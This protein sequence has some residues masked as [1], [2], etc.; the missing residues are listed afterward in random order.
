MQK[1]QRSIVCAGIATGVD[2]TV[3]NG[4]AFP[5]FGFPPPP[6]PFRFRLKRG[7]IIGAKRVGLNI[8]TTLI[9]GLPLLGALE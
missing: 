3:G 4:L 2:A 1:E 6:S 7:D 9:A 8:V 5:P